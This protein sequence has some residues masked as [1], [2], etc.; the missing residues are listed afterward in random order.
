MWQCERCWRPLPRA[1]QAS[2]YR[3]RIQGVPWRRLRR[4]VV[5]AKQH[6][7]VSPKGDQV[8]ALGAAGVLQRNHSR[9]RGVGQGSRP[10]RGHLRHQGI[11]DLDSQGCEGHEPQILPGVRPGPRRAPADHPR[12]QELGVAFQPRP[13]G[14]VGEPAP[15]GSRRAFPARWGRA[16]LQERTPTWLCQEERP[17]GMGSG[18][19]RTLNEPLSAWRRMSTPND[20]LSAWR[21][22]GS[23]S[24][25]RRS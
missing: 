23:E 22:D 4:A 20:P 9:R 8:P 16:R 17:I 11:V 14:V 3:S 12:H 24:Y 21:R 6:R 10:D 18:E 15:I 13:A 1:V 2:R 25:R 19:E 7:R 5:A